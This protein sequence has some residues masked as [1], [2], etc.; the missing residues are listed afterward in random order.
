VGGS[1]Q[2]TAA[3][4]GN[5]TGSETWT[6]MM[7]AGQAVIIK[8]EVSRKIVKLQMPFIINQG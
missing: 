6:G 1:D 4:Q 8:A 2:L 5:S 7:H 3:A